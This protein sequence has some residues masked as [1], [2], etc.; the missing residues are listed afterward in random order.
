MKPNRVF[1]QLAYW[2]L[3]NDTAMTA[4]KLNESGLAFA[5]AHIE[6]NG[7]L[8]L[9]KE[10]RN[11]PFTLGVSAGKS[12]WSISVE[13]PVLAHDHQRNILLGIARF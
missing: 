9:L 4:Q 1:P 8:V 3:R 13:D 7:G 5:A 6:C 12:C 11:S 2:V 10:E